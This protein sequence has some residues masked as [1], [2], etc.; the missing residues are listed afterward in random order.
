MQT[1]YFRPCCL[2]LNKENAM[3]RITVKEAAEILDMPHQAVRAGLEQGVLPIGVAIKRNRWTYYI[4]REKLE[5]W[6]EG[7]VVVE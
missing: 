4:Y 2:K 7:R 1:R 5:A 3:E 6:L